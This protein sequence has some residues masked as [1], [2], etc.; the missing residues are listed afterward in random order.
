MTR[1]IIDDDD[2]DDDDTQ[3]TI[4]NNNN[5]SR[6]S[7]KLTQR[8]RITNNELQWEWVRERANSRKGISHWMRERNVWVYVLVLTRE[9]V[10]V[11]VRIEMKIKMLT[12]MYT[13]RFSVQFQCERAHFVHLLSDRLR[14]LFCWSLSHLM[15]L[16]C[17][18]HAL[19][20]QLVYTCV[21]YC[22]CC[23]TLVLGL[24]SLCPSSLAVSI[25]HIQACTH[26]SMLCKPPYCYAHTL[27]R[28]VCAV[29]STFF[30]AVMFHLMRFP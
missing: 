4:W 30:Y 6:S 7:K 26:S 8:E 9:C 3:I 25:S 14:I 17:I 21:L 13:I 19:T 16:V 24:F 11:C 2:D 5:K 20:K 27:H 22:C 10:C 28:H 12:S 23:F 1:E 18:S 29:H 15:Y